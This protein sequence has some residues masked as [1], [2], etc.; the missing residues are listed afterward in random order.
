VVHDVAV[1]AGVGRSLPVA[2]CLAHILEPASPASRSRLTPGGAPTRGGGSRRSER[3]ASAA[4]F[5]C[6][7]A[8]AQQASP[9]LST[10]A[11][12]CARCAGARAGA[13]RNEKIVRFG[14]EVQLRHSLRPPPRALERGRPRSLSPRGEACAM[15]ASQGAEPGARGPRA[16][17]RAEAQRQRRCISANGGARAAR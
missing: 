6:E 8:G 17:L 13:P 3:T 7:A 14:A 15:P 4:C 9:A 10:A 16:A 12:R 1:D 2:A 11:H 5:L